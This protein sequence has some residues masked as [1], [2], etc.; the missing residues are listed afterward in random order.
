MGTWIG[1]GAAAGLTGAN[2]VKI[3]PMFMMWKETEEP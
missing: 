3:A 1:D 2:F